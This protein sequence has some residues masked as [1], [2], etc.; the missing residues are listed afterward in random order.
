MALH[1]CVTMCTRE[2]PE[3]LATCLNSVLPQLAES[4]VQT[5]LIV[6]ENSDRPA[7]HDLIMRY[8]EAFPAV[9]IEHV[10]EAELG[11]PFARNAG[12]EQALKIHADWIVFI[13][14]DEEAC[15]GW[16]E[17]LT[18]AVDHWDA[19]VFHGPVRQIYA[20]DCPLWIRMKQFHGGENGTIIAGAA[21][22]NTMAH[23]RL[24]SAS[25]LGLRFDTSLRFS[26]GS[27]VELFS[28]A[29]WKGATI[30]WIND[31]VVREHVPAAR[32]T[33]DWLLQR[34]QR[35][36]ANW[37]TITR[38]HNGMISA[39]ALGTSRTMRLAIE[40]FAALLLFPVIGFRG[41]KTA[42]HMFRIRTKL[43][44][45]RG[46]SLPLLGFSPE[47]YRNVEGH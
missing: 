25:G 30:R 39:L 21:T 12:I 4:A 19:D 10:I 7:C 6:V 9:R 5:S 18:A 16:I 45:L 33:P 20:S 22:N 3:M 17:T 28:R 1:L 31:A 47:P 24:F 41:E 23:S 32:Q 2:R 46:Y 11:I 13:D 44:K 26:G 8:K 40:A 14:D 38:K 37:V 34:A 36:A 15:E 27:D 43:A 29:T 42:R 35:D